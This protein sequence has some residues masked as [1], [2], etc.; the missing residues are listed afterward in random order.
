MAHHPRTKSSS[1]LI[2]AG[3]FIDVPLFQPG[4]PATFLSIF[5][6]AQPSFRIPSREFNPPPRDESIPFRNSLVFE[7]A[8][9]T[10]TFRG[11]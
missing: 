3:P 6:N 10:A 5:Q 8:A 2:R 7:C 11:V 4:H 9:I 1:S